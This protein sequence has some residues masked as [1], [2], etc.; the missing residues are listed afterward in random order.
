MPDNMIDY[1]LIVRSR[2]H[3][4]DILYNSELRDFGSRLQE[5]DDIINGVIAGSVV[6]LFIDVGVGVGVG[7]REGRIKRERRN[8][9]RGQKRRGGEMIRMRVISRERDRDRW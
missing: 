5:G 4:S 6:P 9:E 8:R 2:H 3:T 1:H 7:V